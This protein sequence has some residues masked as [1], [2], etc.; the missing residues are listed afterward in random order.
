MDVVRQQYCAHF[1]GLMVLL[2]NILVRPEDG[3]ASEDL[4]LATASI[5]KYGKLLNGYQC[6]LFDSVNLVME[7]LCKR[8]NNVLNGAGPIIDMEGN[9]L[10]DPLSSEAN[11]YPFLSDD[12]LDSLGPGNQLE[13]FD[14]DEIDGSLF[15]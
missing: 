7:D 4:H 6:A 8:A 5:E 1:S 15:G 2:G 13:S 12:V 3:A 9:F 10:A 11:I 14:L